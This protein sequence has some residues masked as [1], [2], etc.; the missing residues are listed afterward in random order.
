[1]LNPGGKVPL[2]VDGD[3]KLFES[4]AILRYLHQTRNTPNHWYPADAKKRGKV[5]EYLDWHHGNIRA[6][7]S[8]YFGYKYLLPSRG[9][10]VS[11]NAIKTQYD[12]TQ[13]ALSMIET[14]WLNDEN[15]KYL[16]GDEITIA[17]LSLAC[18]LQMTLGYNLD[19]S[20]YPR[21]KAYLDRMNNYPGV[22]E[23]FEKS[24]PFIKALCDSV[25]KAQSPK[26]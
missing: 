14:Y 25:D 23:L 2:I 22:K 16:I 24:H 18:E 12:L 21:T 3:Y 9:I 13:K 4:H 6:G 8:T 26:L 19:Y 20:K 1:M 17:D 7:A 11:E 10:K 5:D 15:Q